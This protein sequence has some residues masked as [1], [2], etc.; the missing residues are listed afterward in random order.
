MMQKIITWFVSWCVMVHYVLCNC[1]SIVYSLSGQMGEY[2]ADSSYFR[3]DCAEYNLRPLHV[4]GNKS[5][6]N[7]YLASVS[8]LLHI[9][10]HYSLGSNKTRPV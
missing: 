9:C 7:K 3:Q 6:F 2:E 4:L 5:D 1:I 10:T 8:S